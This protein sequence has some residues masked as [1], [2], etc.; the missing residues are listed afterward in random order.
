MKIKKGGI[1]REVSEKAF[2][3]KWKSLGYEKIKEEKEN[4]VEIPEEVNAD[5]YTVKE[6][7]NICKELEISG[8]SN[9]NQDELIEMINKHLEEK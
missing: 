8:Y 5:D 9:K 2:K 7:K 1:Y 3:N 4:S 6:L